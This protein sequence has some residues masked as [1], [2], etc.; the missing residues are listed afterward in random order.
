MIPKRDC[1]GEHTSSGKKG[2]K[3]VWIDTCTL[4]AVDPSRAST[5]PTSTYRH[6]SDFPGRLR[7]TN[8]SAP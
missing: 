1:N 6:Y 2:G 3:N 8:G 4:P 7:G 5:Y